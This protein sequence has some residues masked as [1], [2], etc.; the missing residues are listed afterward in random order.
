MNPREQVES[1]WS[2]YKKS[3]ALNRTLRQQV[4]EQQAM[5]KL[6]QE[7]TATLQALIRQLQDQLAKDSHNSGKPPGSDGLTKGRRKSLRRSGRRP[8]AANAGTEDAP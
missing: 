3:L 5:I 4:A 6:L 7:Q 8:C 2:S 1:S